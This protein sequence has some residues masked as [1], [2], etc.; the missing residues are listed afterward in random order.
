MC[1]MEHRQGKQIKNIKKKEGERKAE[2]L[3]FDQNASGGI[4]SITAC[5][6]N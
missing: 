5:A 3:R 6:S 2:A 4:S 1:G